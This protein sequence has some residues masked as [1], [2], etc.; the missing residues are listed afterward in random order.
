[1]KARLYQEELLQNEVSSGI[2][3]L[4]PFLIARGTLSALTGLWT[5][6]CLAYGV[7]I[8]RKKAGYLLGGLNHID[9][10]FHCA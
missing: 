10:S 7:S 8:L 9:T 5:N 3:A 1:M 4:E 2:G 6:S